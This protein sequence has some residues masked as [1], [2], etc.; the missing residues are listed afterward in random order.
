MFSLTLRDHLHVTFSQI[1]E[2]HKS[3]ARKALSQARWG[4][5]LRGV[6]ALLMGGV[7]IAAVSAAY[8]QG[9]VATIVAAVTGG[10]RAA[11]AARAPRVRFRWVRAGARRGDQS[12]VAHP[13]ALSCPSVGPAR[14]HRRC[15]RRT[16]APRRIDGRAPA[17]LQQRPD[18]AVRRPSG[19][20]RRSRQDRACEERAG[21]MT[22]LRKR[23]ESSVFSRP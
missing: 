7:S 10:R 18:V 19:R 15:R 2:Q 23:G 14:G 16:D 9:R 5:R 21:G 20:D 3:H 13:R 8:G 22:L 1:V 4:R 6:E 12:P 17:H 11:G